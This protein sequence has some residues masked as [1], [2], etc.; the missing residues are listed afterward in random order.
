MSARILDPSSLSSDYRAEVRNQVA[1][2]STPPTVVGLLSQNEGPAAVYASYAQ[3]GAAQVGI[4]F[5]LRQTSPDKVEREIGRINGDPDIHGLFLY[6]PILG[7]D[8]RWLRE[9]VSPRKDIEGMHSFWSARL[10]EN[11]R[12]LDADQTQ[13]ALLPCTPLAI[14]KLLE[15]AGIDH[16]GDPDADGLPL[17]GVN[18]VV[19]NRSDIVGRPLA[20]MMANDG[21]RVT[22][23]DL[24]GA[25]VLEP[26]HTR[27]SYLVKNTYV[28]RDQA[29]ATADVV[30]TGV[31]SRDFELVTADEIKPGA[32]CLNFSQFRNFDDSI[33]DK[34]SVF[35]PRVG[36]MTVTMALRNTVRVAQQ[37]QGLT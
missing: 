37:L 20:A 11:R 2:M 1:A 8:D 32:I 3:K 36:P 14:M 5:E 33:L 31:P 19:I 6:Y 22:S 34:A 24:D 27:H 25:L 12:F 18:A 23:F 15:S 28:T 4:N 10:Y 26:D 13:Q 21:A 7:A 29:L 35:I 9:I 16:R 17:R 30:V